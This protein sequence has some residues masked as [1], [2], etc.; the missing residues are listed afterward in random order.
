MYKHDIPGQRFG[1]LM[2][3]TVLSNIY[4]RFFFFTEKPSQSREFIEP[5]SLLSWS[6]AF[7]NGHAV[8]QVCRRA[9]LLMCDNATFKEIPHQARFSTIA[10]FKHKNRNLMVI[11]SMLFPK[12]CTMCH[13]R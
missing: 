8:L 6:A 11:S 2:D 1:D 3:V 5:S 7:L 12:Q 4:S 10:G 9:N 13:N